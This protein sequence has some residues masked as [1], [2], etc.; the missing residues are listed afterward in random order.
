MAVTP[1]TD[2]ALRRIADAS[3]VLRNKVDAASVK[4]KKVEQELK[5]DRL[6][7]HCETLCGD[8]CALGYSRMPDGNFRIYTR[9]PGSDVKTPWLNSA[10]TVQA[11]TAPYL[12][13][14]LEALAKKAEDL[15]AQTE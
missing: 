9:P 6:G 7:L 8:T 3:A 5:D 1:R 13:S 14:L 12:P 11:I 4:I 2:D 15:L 10:L